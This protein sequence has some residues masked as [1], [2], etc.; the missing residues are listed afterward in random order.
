MPKF[1]L[2]PAEAGKLVDYFAAVA[3]VEFPYTADVRGKAVETRE[4]KK[5]D[6]AMRLV[7]DRTAYCAK[8]HLIGDFRPSG[9]TGTI[10]GPNLE[11][12]GG[13]IRPEYLRRWLADPKSLL[14][15]TGMPVNFPPQGPRMGQDLL[16]GD[17]GEQLDAVLDLLLHYDIYLKRQT[18]IRARIEGGK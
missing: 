13:R 9:E 2:S 8:C 3:G 7:T 11:D 5:W 4:E 15:Y 14:P 17:G 12:V 18:S 1:A 10:L 6:A 16:P